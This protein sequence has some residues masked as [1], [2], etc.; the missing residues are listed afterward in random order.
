L[1]FFGVF[2]SLFWLINGSDEDFLN[3]KKKKTND[4]VAKGKN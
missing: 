3:Q 1:S 4:V 2:G